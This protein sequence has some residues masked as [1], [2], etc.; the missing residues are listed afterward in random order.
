MALG[1]CEQ[2]LYQPL[3]FPLFVLRALFG[4]P[5]ALRAFVDCSEHLLLTE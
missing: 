3:V 4:Q 1:I 5:F 2:E